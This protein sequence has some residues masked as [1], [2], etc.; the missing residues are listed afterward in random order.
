MRQS[1]LPTLILLQ[2]HNERKF[3]SLSQAS[4]PGGLVVTASGI[5][6]MSPAVQA[7]LSQ[8]A[9]PFDAAVSGCILRGLCVLPSSSTAVGSTQEVDADGV[10]N[11][12]SLDYSQ[13]YATPLAAAFRTSNSTGRLQSPESSGIHQPRFHSA[14][15]ITSDRGRDGWNARK[16]CSYRVASS[17]NG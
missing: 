2:P 8:N 6:A 15:A 5:K 17:C 11:V 14:C 16:R 12:N 10:W 7:K 4:A 9:G 13:L 3:C 1:A